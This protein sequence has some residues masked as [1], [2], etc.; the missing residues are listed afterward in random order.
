MD[1]TFHLKGLPKQRFLR[2]GFS[3]AA[4]GS[5][6]YQYQ[7][8]KPDNKTETMTTGDINLHL[9]IPLK[10]DLGDKPQ[11]DPMQGQGMTDGGAAPGAA[12]AGGG[13]FTPT[14]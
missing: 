4:G 8:P 2:P 3:D 12:M 5:D 9:G 14:G 13:D 11:E 6:L 10:P 7:G 1:V